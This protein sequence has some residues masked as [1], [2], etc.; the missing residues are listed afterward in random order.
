MR[1]SLE[2]AARRIR[3][4]VAAS[5]APGVERFIVSRPDPLVI[6]GLATDLSLEDGDDDLDAGAVSGVR[7]ERGDVL[8]VQ[9]EVEEDGTLSWTVLGVSDGSV[10]NA[11]LADVQALQDQ[12]NEIVIGGGDKHYVHTQ[13]S[14]EAVWEIN[15]NLGKKPSIHVFDTEDRE[16]L[17][18]IEHIDNNSATATWGGAA[19]G[20]ATCD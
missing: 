19:S 20:Y 7:L 14:P 15:H 8:L 13:A 5:R 12:I 2:L 6:D 9:P 10:P 16:R 3:E 4:L 18:D 17:V 11:T 1:H